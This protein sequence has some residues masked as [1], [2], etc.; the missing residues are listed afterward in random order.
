MLSRGPPPAASTAQPLYGPA[1]SSGEAA[2]LPGCPLKRSRKGYWLKVDRIVPAHLGEVFWTLTA[3]ISVKCPGVIAP[4]DSP[5][6][7][8]TNTAF[9]A[10]GTTSTVP[11]GSIEPLFKIGTV[12]PA[13]LTAVP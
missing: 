6:T 11:A 9:E 10:N 2:N 8:C 4:E 7:R 13:E 5:N 12:A 3:V 1:S